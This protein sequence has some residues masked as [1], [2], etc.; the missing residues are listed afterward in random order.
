MILSTSTIPKRQPPARQPAV[1]VCSS[2]AVCSPKS[3]E[4]KRCL[5]CLFSVPRE[6]RLTNNWLLDCNEGLTGTSS[7]VAGNFILTGKTFPNS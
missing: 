4:E 7:Q 6:K 3:K 2:E 5:C 1:T